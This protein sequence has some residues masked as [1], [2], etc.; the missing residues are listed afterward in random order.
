MAGGIWTRD[1]EYDSGDMNKDIFS[2]SSWLLG[3]SIYNCYL[4]INGE[5]YTIQYSNIMKTQ[6]DLKKRF[7]VLMDELDF[8]ITDEDFLL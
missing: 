8:G 6:E 7:V 4:M 2:A 3:R 1:K 5:S